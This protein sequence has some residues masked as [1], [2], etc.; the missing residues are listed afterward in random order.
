VEAVQAALQESAIAPTRLVLE[1][2][3]GT[4]LRMGKDTDRTLRALDAL[5]IGIAVDD[6]GTG[7]ASM[8]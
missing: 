6:F 1:I 7:Y 4:I 3:E 5:G 2:T 8:A